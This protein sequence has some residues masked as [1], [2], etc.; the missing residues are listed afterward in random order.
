[1]YKK[2]VTSICLKHESM[3]AAFTD[4]GKTLKSDSDVFS[5]TQPMMSTAGK[6]FSQ[7]IQME[8]R[9]DDAFMF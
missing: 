8:C 9:K 2:M 6:S 1:M 7:F 5:V 3:Q 4:V